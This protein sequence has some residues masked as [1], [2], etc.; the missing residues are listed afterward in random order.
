MRRCAGKSTL[1][2]QVCLAA[3]LAQA[4]AWVP[5]QSLELTPVDAIFV[6]MGARDAI[7]TGQARKFELKCWP[8][9]SRQPVAPS[10][11]LSGPSQVTFTTSAGMHAGS[12]LTCVTSASCM[13]AAG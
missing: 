9:V 8:L 3:L 5:A 11:M 13:L 6:R 7:M 2:R 10:R 12:R 1:L 4:G